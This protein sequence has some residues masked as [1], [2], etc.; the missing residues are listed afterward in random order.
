MGIGGIVLAV[1]P[2][3]SWANVALLGSLNLFQL[4]RAGGH[5]PGV[6]WIGIIAG[7]L[8]AGASFGKTATQQ[9]K[10]IG[11]VLGLICGLGSW[12]LLSKLLDAVR[13]TQGFATVG[14]GPYVAVGACVAIVI[15]AFLINPEQVR[16][17]H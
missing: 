3:L 17:T 2:F 15:S 8:I 5:A 16:R 13:E 6:V 4:Y 14:V 1:S 12:A 10:V 7:L 11:I 9:T